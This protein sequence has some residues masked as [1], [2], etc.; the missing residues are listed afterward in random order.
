MD[1]E[2]RDEVLAD[3]ND[4]IEIL[5]QKMWMDSMNLRSWGITIKTWKKVIFNG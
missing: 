4:I 1:E 3:L 5:R 2:A